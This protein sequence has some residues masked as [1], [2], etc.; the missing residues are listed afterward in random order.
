MKIKIQQ[1]LFGKCHSWSIVAQNIAKQLIKNHSVDLVSTDG[2]K[3]AF[4]SKELKKHIK[5]TPDKLY[6]M[7]LSYTIPHNMPKFLNYGAK[8]RFGIWCYEFPIIPAE[9]IK[10]K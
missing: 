7:Q 1:F 5:I 10:Y 4:I 6:D 9:Q 3:E 8:N 2:I